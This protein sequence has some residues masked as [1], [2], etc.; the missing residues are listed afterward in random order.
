MKNIRRILK[1]NKKSLVIVAFVLL[2]APAV[3]FSGPLDKGS[4]YVG[5][6]LGHLSYDVDAISGDSNPGALVARLGYF[7]LN[8]VA[9]EARYGFGLF[10]DSARLL[11]NEGAITRGDLE[12][13][14]LV[15]AYVAGYLPLA[16][17]ASAY[18]LIGFTDAT[19]TYSQNFRATSNSDNGISFGFGA[20]IYMPF[21]Q[22]IT[23]R[24]HWSLGIEYMRYLSESGYKLTSYGIGASVHF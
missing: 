18:A 19:T 20:N 12:L 23:K 10:D 21:V 24:G 16:D 11:D 2:I 17:I 22:D 6:Q 9:L 5:L 13:D 3:A 4:G 8:Q 14:Y 1:M 7:V 15:G